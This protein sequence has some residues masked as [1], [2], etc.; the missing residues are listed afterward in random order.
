V[1]GIEPPSKFE[2]KRA[3]DS[4]PKGYKTCTIVYFTIIS[5]RH[6]EGYFRPN[7]I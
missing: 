1:T 3:G 7:R 5:I 2:S 4:M 6:F